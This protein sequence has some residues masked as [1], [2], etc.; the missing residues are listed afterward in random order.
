M[1]N[2]NLYRSG[3]RSIDRLL[4]ILIIFLLAIVLSACEKGTPNGGLQP[5][6]ST[7]TPLP[8]TPTPDL[9]TT[10]TPTQLP[11]GAEGN[12]IVIGMVFTDSNTQLPA[13]T[14]FIQYLADSTGFV[15][16]IS[17][18]A[19]EF[20]LLTAMDQE[21]VSIAW[22]QP[23]EYLYASQNDIAQV[24]LLTSHYGLYGYGS[25]F[26][27]RA[28]SG[29][30]ID[31]QPISGSSTENASTALRQFAEKTPC[32]VNTR[33][34][35]GYA[36]PLGLFAQLNIALNEPV[37]LQ[38]HE[39]VVRAVYSGGIC[40][41]GVTYGIVGDPRT[42]SAIQADLPDVMD[43]VLIAW[44]SPAD[45]PSLNLSFATHVSGDLRFAITS[46][47]TDFAKSQAGLDTLSKMNNYLIDEIRPATDDEYEPLRLVIEASGI[48]FE[49]FISR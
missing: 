18:F 39:S 6:L 49:T 37:F 4:S 8:V 31:F 36:Y 32:M 26:Y 34:L 44:Q 35:S 23:E 48:D 9:N 15:F 43:K 28:D 27:V 42:A 21:S 38:T 25:N 40:D 10:P 1:V 2:K 3:H 46:A 29:F 41:F 5:L 19:S 17:E 7:P 11:P 24:A 30:K 47:V 12:P 45:I 22:L 14:D 16:T 13:A 33:S 20:E